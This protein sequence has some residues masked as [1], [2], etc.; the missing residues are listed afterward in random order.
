MT[1]IFSRNE[2][3]VDPFRRMS[4]EQSESSSVRRN[5]LL[6]VKLSVSIILLVIL[7]EDRLSR[8]YGRPR[9]WKV[10]VRLLAALVFAIS[11]LVA[12]WRGTFC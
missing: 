12:V 1:V 2:Y 10:R 8:S 3:S 5:V 6:A 9:D 4:S 7:F 11:T